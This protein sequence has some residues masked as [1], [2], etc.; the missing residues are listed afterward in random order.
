MPPRA[1]SV[2]PKFLRQGIRYDD[3]TEEEKDDWDA[4]EWDED[5]D[6]PDRGRTPRRSTGSCSTPTPSTRSSA[7]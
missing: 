1:V 4:L 3:L 6:V 7:T 2:P 5:G